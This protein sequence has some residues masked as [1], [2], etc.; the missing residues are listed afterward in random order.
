MLPSQLANCFDANTKEKEDFLP[1][2]ENSSN[3]WGEINCC[4]YKHENSV[5]FCYYDYMIERDDMFL[6]ICLSGFH[7]FP[8]TLHQ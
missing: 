6:L 7:Y 8:M 5:F 2:D 1:L 3:F 4:Y